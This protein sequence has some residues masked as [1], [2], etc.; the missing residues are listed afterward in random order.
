MAK[1]S[2]S[3]TPTKKKCPPLG[4][5]YYSYAL[6]VVN[7]KIYKDL[8]FLPW[9]LLSRR[10]TAPGFGI[11]FFLDEPK[12]L[13]TMYKKKIRTGDNTTDTFWNHHCKIA[14]KN[15]VSTE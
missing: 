11:V 3:T 14:A 4:P 12:R 13:L 9:L 8:I 7:L 10:V 5:K 1:F 2:P 15:V 6:L